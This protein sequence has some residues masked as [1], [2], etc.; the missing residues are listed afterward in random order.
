MATPTRFEIVRAFAVHIFTA[1]GAALA[2]LALIFATGGHWAAM[3]FCLGM[4]LVVDGVDGQLAREFKV[5]EILPRWSGE[6]LDLI[7]DF[8]TYVFVPAYAIAASG[9]L[10]PVLAIPS[11]IVVA[12]TGALYFADRQMKTPDNYFRGF[13]AV[14]NLAAFYL[15]LLEPPPWLA[16]AM[17]ATLAVLSFAPIKF[18]HPLRVKRLRVFNIALLAGWAVL[19]FLAVIQD[20]TPGPY[21][22]W[23]LV[24]IAI[25]FFGA[26]LLR[27]P[28]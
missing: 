27:S 25:Y 10:P 4:A 21:V 20:L 5:A 22:T 26:G 24:A 17:I 28:G 2:L 19:A 18:L 16:T 9:L 1:C 7:V 6:T 23:P 14:W 13:P 8:T 15:Y 11:G 3:F 12:I